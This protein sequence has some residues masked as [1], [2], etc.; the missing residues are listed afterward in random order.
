[1]EMLPR[2]NDKKTTQLVAHLLQMAGGRMNFLRLLKLLYIIDREALRR[3]DWPVTFDNYYSMEHGPV[4]SCTYNLIKEDASPSQLKY[5]KQFISER[6]DN[7]ISMLKAPPPDDLSEA[8]SDLAKEVSDKHKHL[9]EWDLRDLT[10]T[11][12]EWNDPGDSRLPIQLSDILR[13]VGKT[14]K[15][16]KEILEELAACGFEEKLFVDSRNAD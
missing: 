16:S 13:A 2:F 11:F 5:W 15:E 14:D 9:D 10:H 8:E 7:D 6:Q 1:M 12:E 3:W 4:L